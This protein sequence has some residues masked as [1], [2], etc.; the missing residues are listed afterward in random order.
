[1]PALYSTNK[2][3]HVGQ[4]SVAQRNL[5][6]QHA[7]S[8]VFEK[9]YLPHHTTADV[10]AAY[11]GFD[12]QIALLRAATGLSRT[13]DK[14]RPWKLKAE[15][16]RQVQDH[17]KVKLYADALQAYQKW[18]DAE[19]GGVKAIR[20][21]PDFEDL[22]EEYQQLVRNVRNE[23]SVQE[24]AYLEEIKANFRKEQPVKDVQ[25]QLDG[26]SAD[27]NT[28]DV[29]AVAESYLLSERIRAISS[30]LTFVDSEDLP[31]EVE[32]NRRTEAVEAVASLCR[33]HDGHRG[34]SRCQTRSAVVPDAKEDR[35]SSPAKPAMSSP[36]VCKPLQCS[37]CLH[38]IEADWNTRVKEY[39]RID[40]LKRHLD[41]YHLKRY[42]EGKSIKCPEC[43][44]VCDH[45]NHLRNHGG[46]HGILV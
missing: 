32:E 28:D 46:V 11:R 35:S 26:F 30:L 14:R 29:P 44:F 33:V 45:K 42:P 37:F 40:I 41:R 16:R 21:N 24:R 12:P 3:M 13:I 8:R 43:G 34:R 9:R 19:L 36:L 10:V 27:E 5:L 39:A 15:Q 2:G 25:R 4:I 1:M 31:P 23:K 22:Y 6:M 18:V 7:S 38:D 17:P 20:D